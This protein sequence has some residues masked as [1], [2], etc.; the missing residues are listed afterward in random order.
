VLRRV[1]I[2]LPAVFLNPPTVPPMSSFRRF[3]VPF[4]F[5][6]TAVSAAPI[7]ITQFNVPIF[8]NFNTLAN[9][10]GTT[11]PLGWT[12]AESGTGANLSYGAG[13]GSSATGDTYSFGALSSTERALGTLRTGTV[14]SSIGVSFSNLTGAT[15][16]DLE[17]GYTGEQ[18]RLGSTGRADRLDFAYSFDATSLTTGTWSNFDSLDFSTPSTTGATGARDGNLA[19]HQAILSSTIGGLSISAGSNFW[20]RWTDFDAANADDGLAIDNFSLEAV[21]TIV[22]PPPATPPPAVPDSSSVVLFAFTI[23]AVLWLGARYSRLH[24]HVV[25]VRVT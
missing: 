11:V 23:G 14:I 19:V 7:P 3:F 13:I 2:E 16:T 21:Q 12:F 22:T 1:G 4:C 15:I 24:V 20:L 10:A 9:A 25:S 6:A 17:I 5:A 8:E 18:W